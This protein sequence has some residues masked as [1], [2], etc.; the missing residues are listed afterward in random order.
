M[1]DNEVL[2]FSTAHNSS[3]WLSRRPNM[4]RYLRREHGILSLSCNLLSLRS[5]CVPKVSLLLAFFLESDSS[6]CFIEQNRGNTHRFSS[7]IQPVLARYKRRVSIS[8][9]EP[10][11]SYHQKIKMAT[12]CIRLISKSSQRLLTKDTRILWIR[13]FSALIRFT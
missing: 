6:K 5:P 3:G 4:V 2:S 12:F 10:C 11:S 9:R 1:L 7:V 13:L 8:T